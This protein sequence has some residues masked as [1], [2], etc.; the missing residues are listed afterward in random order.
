MRRNTYPDEMVAPVDVMMESEVFPPEEEAAAVVVAVETSGEGGRG[1]ALADSLHP[2][3]GEVDFFRERLSL[4]Q[5]TGLLR[6]LGDFINVVTALCYN[7]SKERENKRKEILK[8]H[9]VAA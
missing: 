2:E 7:L 9:P 8:R 4:P 5:V 1:G 3:G 6:P